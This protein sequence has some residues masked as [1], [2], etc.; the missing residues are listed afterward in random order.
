MK[1]L[2]LVEV[3]RRRWDGTNDKASKQDGGGEGVFV[4]AGQGGS[5]TSYGRMVETGVTANGVGLRMERC[6]DGQPVEPVNQGVRGLDGRLRSRVSG[7][8]KGCVV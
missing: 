3:G 5:V 2:D 4:V 6:T 8:A 7:R 1:G